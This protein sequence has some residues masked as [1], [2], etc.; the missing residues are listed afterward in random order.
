MTNVNIRMHTNCLEALD[1]RLAFLGDIEECVISIKNRYRY[2]AILG[3]KNLYKYY[4]TNEKDDIKEYLG[5]FNKRRMV[6]DAN[7]NKYDRLYYFLI[8][9]NIYPINKWIADADFEPVQSIIGKLKH[10]RS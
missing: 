6:F 4:A 2:E 9:L 7:P 3:F 8:K 10:T 5:M 1:E